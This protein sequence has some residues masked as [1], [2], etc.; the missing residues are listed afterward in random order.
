MA[1]TVV[2]DDVGMSKLCDS[3]LA[4]TEPR[5]V[6]HIMSSLDVLLVLLLLRVSVTMTF[7]I[8]HPVAAAPGNRGQTQLSVQLCHHP[9]S[10]AAS[11]IVDQV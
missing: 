3:L 4:W 10:N 2:E 1:Q 5:L 7:G 6:R 11:S 9:R 8:I